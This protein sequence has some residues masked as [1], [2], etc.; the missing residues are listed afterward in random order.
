MERKPD[1]VQNREYILDLLSRCKDILAL[2]PIMQIILNVTSGKNTSAMELASL[3]ETNSTLASGMLAIVNS[4]YFGF[5][6]KISTVSHAVTVLGFQEV[7]NILLSIAAVQVFEQRGPDFL[8]KLWR[9]CF[10]VGVCSRLIAGYLKLKIESKYFV[11]GMLHDVGRIFLSQ[12]VPGKFK[13]MLSLLDKGDNKIT[14]HSLEQGF[15]GISHAE[16][17]GRLLETWRFSGDIIEAVAYHHEPSRAISDKALAA[18]VHLADLIC[19]VKGISP[20]GDRYF[21]SVDKNIIPTLRGLRQNFST[22]DLYAMMG[23][24]DLEIDRQNAFVSVYK[25]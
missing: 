18:C 11:S 16:I 7:Q 21:L 25:H 20:L 17:G 9:H 22:E 6:K 15:F 1:P 13:E 23:Q 4:P 14:Y 2:P 24:L 5:S 3:I 8:E 19:T 12:Y 10:S